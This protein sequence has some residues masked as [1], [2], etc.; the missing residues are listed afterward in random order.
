M[1]LFSFLGDALSCIGSAVA[2]FAGALIEK[3]SP[4]IEVA[5]A[6]V[7]AIGKVVV[8]VAN[9]LGLIPADE[10]VEEL[11]AKT[12]QDGVR[13]Q[14][15]DESMQEYLD[16]LRNDVVLDEE[17]LAKM[18]VKE[19][20]QCSSIGTAMVTNAIAEETGVRISPDF[21]IGMNKM[22]MTAEQFVEVLN[23]FSAKGID[24]M[25]MLPKFFQNRLTDQERLDVY[26]VIETTE[27]KLNPESTEADV[28]RKIDDMGEALNAGK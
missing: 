25:D 26:E 1:G 10:S 6:V 15:E 8:T 19:K 12:M 27:K 2:S 14:M 17:K 18:S 21:L 7:E 28:L 23:G 11:G 3:L 5:K 20:T 9:I 16:Y 4:V 24:D 22:K 13:A